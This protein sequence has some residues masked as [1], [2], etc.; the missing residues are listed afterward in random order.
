MW[1]ALPGSFQTNGRKTCVLQELLQTEIEI[2]KNR[3]SVLERIVILEI[4]LFFE[5]SLSQDAVLAEPKQFCVS[6]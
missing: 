5:G 6:K 4:L 2:L 3:F 1:P